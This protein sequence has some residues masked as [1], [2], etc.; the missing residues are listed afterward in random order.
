MGESED[1][2][3]GEEMKRSFPNSAMFPS[4]NEG[5]EMM[6]SAVPIPRW[7]KIPPPFPLDP[8]FHG[9][10][11]EVNEHPDILHSIPSG[12]WLN[13]A[14]P[15]LSFSLTEQDEKF[16]SF[17]SIFTSDI[18]P[19]QIL[20]HDPFPCD[21][22]IVANVMFVTF[23]PVQSTQFNT[24]QSASI[25]IDVKSVTAI[26]T[27]ALLFTSINPPLPVRLTDETMHVSRDN[28][29][30]FPRIETIGL[31]EKETEEEAEKE[32]SCINPPS[33]TEANEKSTIDA[34]SPPSIPH[35]ERMR[36]DDEQ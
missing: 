30:P 29:L 33:V 5:E 17:I 36:E 21:R 25:V 1:E 7:K 32:I 23:M 28:L 16:A 24:A 9:A 12:I 18:L 15:P 22:E 13:T 27:S 19:P 8:A 3:F 35:M 34:P 26:T 11:H 4:R 14:P 6:K 20:T 2:R 10:V 31:D